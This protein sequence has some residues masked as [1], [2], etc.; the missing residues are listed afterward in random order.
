MNEIYADI[1]EQTRERAKFIFDM[2]IKQPNIIKVAKTLCDYLELITDEYEYNFVLFYFESR[3][4][5]LLKN[6]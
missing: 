3:L 4:E 5:E 1:S 6:E 2:A